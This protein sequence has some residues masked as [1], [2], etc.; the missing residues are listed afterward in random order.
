[1]TF[2][3]WASILLLTPALCC[4][5]FSRADPS[6]SYW[7]AF[8][9]FAWLAFLIHLYWTV[10]ATFHLNWFE[11]F[12]SQAAAHILG[13]VML[14]AIVGCF[15]LSLSSKHSRGSLAAPRR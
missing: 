14:L 15:L 4:Y 8:W 6:N 7:R 3:I 10:F 13:I 11:I 1:V 5:V 9:T 12:H 2:S